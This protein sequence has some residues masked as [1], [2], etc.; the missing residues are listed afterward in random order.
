VRCGGA[1]AW[2]GM[3][4]WTGGKVVGLRNIRVDAI[5]AVMGR[6]FRGCACFVLEGVVGE[7]FLNALFLLL[8]ALVSRLILGL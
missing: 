8:Q 5:R 4:R 7:V 1:V 6:S 3:G 2:D